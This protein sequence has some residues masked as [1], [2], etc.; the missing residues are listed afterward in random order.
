M[1][2]LKTVKPKKLKK[3]KEIINKL[4]YRKYSATNVI[5]NTIIVT[6]RIIMLLFAFSAPVI[7]VL[8]LIYDQGLRY[9]FIYTLSLITFKKG[10]IYNQETVNISLWVYALIA[11]FVLIISFVFGIAFPFLTKNTWKKRAILAFNLLFWP[12]LFGG[13]IY[14]I[15]YTIPLFGNYPEV[16][17]SS[18]IDENNVIAWYYTAL[19]KSYSYKNTW[20]II[21]QSIYIIIMI[22]GIFTIFE[23]D[24]ARRLKIIYWDESFNEQNNYSLMNHV[25]EGRVNFGEVSRDEIKPKLKELNIEQ[26]KLVAQKRLNYILEVKKKKQDKKDAKKLKHHKK[27]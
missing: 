4:K 25:L 16:G 6:S 1:D 20:L 23:A 18:S 9:L 8:A 15:N 14:V 21:L 10:N 26:K 12:L 27:T 24:L 5:I 22:F 3:S 11:I 19:K 2:K 13:I 17:S 7:F